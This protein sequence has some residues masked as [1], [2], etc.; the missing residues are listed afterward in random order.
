MVEKV[1]KFEDVFRV[2]NSKRVKV[3]FNMNPDDR[4]I[5]AWDLLRK[6]DDRWLEMNEWKAFRNA[7]NNL[8]D[9]DYLLAFAQYYPYGSNYYIFGGFYEV[10][11]KRDT[12][13]GRGYTLKLLD[14]FS[15]YRK[16]LIVKL[17]KPVGQSYNLYYDTVISKE[18]IVYEIAP[19]VKAG[20]FTGYTNF[21]LT[22]EELQTIF[23]GNAKKWELALSRV[24]G[25]Y[26]IIDKSDGQIY[27][28]SASDDSQGIWGR[29]KS[30]A[31]VNNLTG[32]NKAF[33]EMKKEGAD[34]IINNFTYSIL[35]IFDMRTDREYIINREN[36]WK[37]VFKTR[38]HGLNKYELQKRH[39]D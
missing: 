24:K 8:E 27:I 10:V 5:P 9:A 1:I 32:G 13:N 31:D 23:K 39:S 28:G 16:R 25:I 6:D 26:C 7:N 21:C 17:N 29:W 37:E 11:E 22:H 36:H 20:E 35:E 12:K 19:S 34:R 18:A 4:T 30:Y 14:K 15:E 33:E 3:K 2:E 38:E